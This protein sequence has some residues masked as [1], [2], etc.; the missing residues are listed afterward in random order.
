[1]HEVR[2]HLTTKVAD[3]IGQKSCWGIFG[4][5]RVRMSLKIRFLK[6]Y[7]K[8]TCGIFLILCMN[9]KQHKVLK[10]TQIIFY[11]VFGLKGAKNS[12]K[13]SFSSFMESWPSEH[14][15]SLKLNY[16]TV[17]GKFLI[18]DFW[19]EGD[20]KCAQNEV[21]QVKSKVSDTGREKAGG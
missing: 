17:L 15:L 13:R 6:V 19:A 11:K 16:L 1:M 2:G 4:A 21:F 18:W 10:L 3:F 20:P 7:R 9:S 5:N 14:L 12:S 8:S